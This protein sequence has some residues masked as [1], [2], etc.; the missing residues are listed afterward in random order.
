[1]EAQ[2]LF[3]DVVTRFCAWVVHLEAMLD[4]QKFVFGCFL[5]L[6]RRQR[7]GRR[8]GDGDV[9]GTMETSGGYER[10]EDPWLFVR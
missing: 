6:R 5:I 7:K 10:Y 3:Y 4:N 8:S 1:M 2:N 9:V